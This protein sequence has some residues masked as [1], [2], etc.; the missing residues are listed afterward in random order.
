MCTVTGGFLQL[1]ALC[2]WIIAIT[3]SQGKIYDYIH[4]HN[5]IILNTGFYWISDKYFHWVFRDLFKFLVSDI[6]FK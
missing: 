3:N 5:I 1:S 6:Y 4:F 2:F